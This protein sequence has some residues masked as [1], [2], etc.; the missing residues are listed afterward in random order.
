MTSLSTIRPCYNG[1]DFILTLIESI[2]KNN[3]DIWNDIEI[4]LVDDGSTDNTLHIL[5]QIA[6]KRPS[7]QVVSKTHGGIADSRNCGLKLAQG[8][9]VTFC[10]QDD[11]CINGWSPFLKRI[12]DNDADLLIANY[13]VKRKGEI[14]NKQLIAND[15]S[16]EGPI[17]KEMVKRC[18]NV[19]LDAS[20]AEYG[21]I[22]QFYPTI[23]NCIFKRSTLVENGITISRYFDYEDDWKLLTDTLL[24]ARKVIFDTRIWYQYSYRNDSESHRGK[25]VDDFFTKRKHLREYYTYCL[26]QL[27]ISEKKKK[28]TLSQFDRGTILSGFMNYRYAPFKDYYFAMKTGLKSCNNLGALFL[29]AVSLKEFILT[30]LLTFHLLG[31]AWCISSGK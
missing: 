9:Y 29:P 28:V 27:Q 6:A 22:P 24:N 31:I 1:Q 16:H 13:S 25:Y 21:Q 20:D 19:P 4:I 11:I 2:E 17:I 15:T 14:H 12:R 5:Q 26:S 8:D 23:W 3:Q 30:L 18:L 7:I 10:D